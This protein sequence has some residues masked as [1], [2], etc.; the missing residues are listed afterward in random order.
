MSD[1]FHDAVPDTYIEAVFGV[2]SL[3]SHHSYILLT[4]RAAR[5]RAWLA[6]ATLARCQAEAAVRGIEIRSP[7]GRRD[8]ARGPFINGPWPL[9]NVMGGVSVG[10]RDRRIDIAELQASDL[11]M[12]MVSFE[13][14][15]EEMGDVDLR[16]I[17]L[18]A[19]GG[20]S[21]PGARPCNLAWIR[22]LVKRCRI[23]GTHAF[24]KQLGAR[25]VVSPPQGQCPTPGIRDRKGG[26]PAEWPADLRVRELPEVTR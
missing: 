21:G 14:L 25:S 16:G 22:S 23:F 1:L 11:A 4:K 19:I 17:D 8:R 15:L 10:T 20:E 18:A 13:P 2:M 9:P 5:M 12:R 6:G 24:V 26:D 3:A 7:A